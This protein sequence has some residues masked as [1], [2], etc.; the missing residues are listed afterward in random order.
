MNSM[1]PVS[2]MVTPN[3]SKAFI[4]SSPFL[5]RKTRGYRGGLPPRVRTSALQPLTQSSIG[6]TWFH[7]SANVKFNLILSLMF[8][9]F[10]IKQFLCWHWLISMMTGAQ[11]AALRQTA[12]PA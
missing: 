9:H 4:S 5:L 1:K 2:K 11:A 6:W 8:T 3:T 12:G 10:L 7:L